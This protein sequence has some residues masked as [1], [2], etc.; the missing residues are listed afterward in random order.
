MEAVF[1]QHERPGGIAGVQDLS[2]AV[3]YELLADTIPAAVAG[4]AVVVEALLLSTV[5]L[6]I[7]YRSP[8]LIC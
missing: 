6:G 2:H 1:A 4:I 3:V 7:E 5:G 8:Y